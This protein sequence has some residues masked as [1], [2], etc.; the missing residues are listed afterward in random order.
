MIE[1]AEA[2]KFVAAFFESWKD[3][4]HKFSSNYT[5]WDLSKSYG[6][7]PMWTSIMLAEPNK[8]LSA[9]DERSFQT[10]ILGGAL[11]RYDANLELNYERHKFDLL[12]LSPIEINLKC[13]ANQFTDNA[14][15]WLKAVKIIVEHENRDDLE[16]EMWKLIHQRAP[17]KV[18]VF[19]D[20]SEEYRTVKPYNNDKSF[21]P[22][23][24]KHNDWLANKIEMLGQMITGA[25][26]LLPPDATEY[27]L[28]VGDRT[29]ANEMQWQY[30]EYLHHDSERRFSTRNVL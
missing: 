9:R 7:K 14:P 17:L 10:D 11:T 5:E 18:L 21:E 27:L 6:N 15:H 1:G 24:I 4:I 26:A 12:G 28:I 16:T 22:N 3:A 8:S 2:K 20:I 30:C 13:L 23:S 25:N 29:K 19:Y